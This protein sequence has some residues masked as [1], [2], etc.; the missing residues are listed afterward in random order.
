MALVVLNQGEMYF[1]DSLRSNIFV[2]GNLTL[3]LFKNNHTPTQTDDNSDYVEADFDGYA[4]FPIDS[5]TPVYLNGSGKAEI[6]EV[7]RVFVQSGVVVTNNV[8]GYY[9]TDGAG[10]VIYA[11][12]DPSAPVAMNAPGKTYTVFG[13][14]TLNSE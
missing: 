4:S 7:N 8:Y 9:V 12:R 13:R 3:R 2:L 6:D 10:N 1:L 5:W 11:E 14:F